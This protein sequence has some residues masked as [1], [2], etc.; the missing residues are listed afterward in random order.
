MQLKQP[1]VI[2]LLLLITACSKK[3]QPQTTVTS[4]VKVT[5]V[6]KNST[7]KKD[8]K[9]SVVVKKPVVRKIKTPVPKVLTV[10]DRAAKKTADGRLYYDLEGH[11]YWRNYN[12][13]KY[14]LF[15]KNMYSNPA[16]KP[17]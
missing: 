13:G 9:D 17:Q 3:H 8:S 14:Y 11:R 15:N 7:I 5:D 16:F 6:E 2:L 12:D 10:D 4:S 1:A